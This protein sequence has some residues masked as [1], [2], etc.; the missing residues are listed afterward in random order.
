MEASRPSNSKI[1]LP[2][3]NASVKVPPPGFN[4]SGSGSRRIAPGRRPGSTARSRWLNVAPGGLGVGSVAAWP[5][6]PISGSACWPSPLSSTSAVQPNPQGSTR[7]AGFPPCGHER[8]QRDRQDVDAVPLNA[9]R[10]RV[11][12][13]RRRHRHL[14]PAGMSSMPRRAGICTSLAS[15]TRLSA[16]SHADVSELSSRILMRRQA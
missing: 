10:R 12:Y 15:L 11:R 13:S 4:R 9:R 6:G 3:P 5:R 16:R 1:V 7:A 2:A 8:A 14:L